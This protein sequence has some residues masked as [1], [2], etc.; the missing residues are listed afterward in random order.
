MIDGWGFSTAPLLLGFRKKEGYPFHELLLSKIQ[1]VN[2]SLNRLSKKETHLISEGG[3]VF[4]GLS[5]VWHHQNR[6]SVLANETKS[7]ESETSVLIARQDFNWVSHEGHQEKA[8]PVEGTPPSTD[9]GEEV[10]PRFRR[11]QREA[12]AGQAGEETARN[13]EVEKTERRGGVGLGT[14][15]VF[16]RRSQ[17]NGV[18]AASKSSAGNTQSSHDSLTARKV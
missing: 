3:K 7:R 2:G 1:G 9:T 15:K 12:I 18:S 5:I 17:I 4:T 11:P 8:E 14:G 16:L 6:G 10:S 13:P